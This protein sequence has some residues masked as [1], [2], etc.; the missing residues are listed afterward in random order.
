MLIGSQPQPLIV[1][2]VPANT[3]AVLPVAFRR[4]TGRVGVIIL[5]PAEL[6]PNQENC[7][8]DPWWEQQTAAEPRAAVKQQQGS[9]WREEGRW[10]R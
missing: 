5:M 4:H 3:G 8:R 2:G 6:E 7:S 10:L 1:Q 9:R